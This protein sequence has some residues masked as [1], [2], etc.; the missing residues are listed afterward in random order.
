MVSAVGVAAARL[1]A[2]RQSKSGPERPVELLDGW[3]LLAALLV[4]A[5]DGVAFFKERGYA[6]LRVVR[7]RVLGHD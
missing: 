4:A 2:A 1:P 7:E 3:R 6:L 5:P